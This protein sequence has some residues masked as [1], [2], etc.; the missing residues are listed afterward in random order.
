MT[1]PDVHLTA[2]AVHRGAERL[3]LDQDALRARAAYAYQHGRPAADCPAPLRAL[4]DAHARLHPGRLHVV[5]KREVFGFAHLPRLTL[6]T[7][8]LIPKPFA[9]Y[10]RQLA[11][12][13]PQALGR[14]RQTREE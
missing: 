2:H 12:A 6:V 14:V 9:A 11:G 3:R 4:L 1:C 5:L 13:A 10:L 7:V 8:A